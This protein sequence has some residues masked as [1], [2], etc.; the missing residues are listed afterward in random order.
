M[1]V[2]QGKFAQVTQ[3]YLVDFKEVILLKYAIPRE[4]AA[5]MLGG[6]FIPWESRGIR[7]RGCSFNGKDETA[8]LLS[9]D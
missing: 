6:C 9:E 8:F 3:W 2:I 1:I 7:I 5:Y 4:T